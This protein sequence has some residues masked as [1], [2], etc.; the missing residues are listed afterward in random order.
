MYFSTI[1]LIKLSE[2][3]LC[4]KALY[5]VTLGNSGVDRP[6]WFKRTLIKLL[7]RLIFV[8]ILIEAL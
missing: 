2:L 6:L 5:R 1:P 3:S 7:P 8:L 4:Q